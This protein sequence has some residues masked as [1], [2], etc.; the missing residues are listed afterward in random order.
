MIAALILLFSA[1]A[2]LQFFASYCH[3]VIA[4]CKRKELSEQVREVTGIVN[5]V[6]RGEEFHRLVQLV[7]LCPEPGDDSN[8]VRA[9]RGYFRLL[10]L[11]RAVLR[12]FLPQ[13]AVWADREREGCAYFAAVA[14]DR[15]IAYSRELMVQQMTYRP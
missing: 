7:G 11:L 4:A 1:A 9:V 15:R 2:L 12:E 13:V 5:R 8:M 10:S 14:L 6:V 3:S